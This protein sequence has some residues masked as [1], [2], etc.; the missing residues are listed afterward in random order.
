MP[1]ERS[2]HKEHSSIL[3]DVL[4]ALMLTISLTMLADFAH[5]LLSADPD[6][7]GIGAISIQAALALAASTTFTESG[8]DWLKKAGSNNARRRCGLAAV[9]FVLVGLIWELIP[10]R[11]AEYY[12]ERGHA[13]EKVDDPKH[14]DPSRAM[15]DYERAIA[16][17]PELQPVYLN[18]GEVLEDFYRYDEA[19]EQ[20]KKAIVADRTDP[21]P[22]NNLARV[23]LA[24]G[25]AMTALRIANDGLSLKPADKS[26]VSALL[27]NQ[28]WA[29]Y[30]LGFYEQAI[31]DAAA[32]DSTAG[33]CIL[34]KV[35]LKLHR[36]ADASAAWARFNQRDAA[37]P[38]TASAVQPD[39]QLL[40]QEKTQEKEEGEDAKK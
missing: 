10:E 5:R 11:L 25:K 23:L 37:A 15:R 1:E 17:S 38:G 19:A 34:G 36:A 3:W 7:I 40:A 30:E 24:D 20:Y 18:L 9:A 26:T 35:Y 29:E 2:A 12:Y 16:L 14:G 4:A 13:L 32:S 22:Y 39:C 8:W 31:R 27:K 33:D 21:I 6:S 28:A